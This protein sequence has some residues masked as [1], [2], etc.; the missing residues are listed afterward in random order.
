[1]A[2]VVVFGASGVAAVAAKLN[3]NMNKVD[4]SALVNP[5]DSPT[6][7]PDQYRIYRGINQDAIL[8]FEE[9]EFP[10]LRDRDDRIVAFVLW[11]SIQ[12]SL[13]EG[14]R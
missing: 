2:A 6:K 12:R 8:G 14:R 3:G 7:E 1:M 4:V 13:F 10:E 11:T 5:I 9:V